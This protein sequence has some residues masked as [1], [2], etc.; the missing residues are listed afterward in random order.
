MAGE[1]GERPPAFPPGPR[2]SF[3]QVLI[4]SNR[5]AKVAIPI[6]APSFTDLG[7]P[8]V[9]FSKE[10][11]QSSLVPLSFS[12]VAKCSYGRPAI[13]KIKSCLL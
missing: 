5:R 12:I 13:P 4:E 1:G 3:A 9:F 10:D 7:E 8:A 11:V 6:K 2:R